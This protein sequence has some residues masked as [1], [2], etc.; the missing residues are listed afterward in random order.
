MKSPPLKYRLLVLCW[1]LAVVLY[2][3][4]GYTIY[5]A[6]NMTTLGGDG[7]KNYYTYLY[8]VCYSHGLWFGGMNYPFGEHCFY[9]DGQPL[10]SLPLSFIHQHIYRLTGVQALAIMHWSIGLSY[11]AGIYFLFRLLY[12]YGVRLLPAI[13]FSTLIMLLSPQVLKC[14]AHFALSNGAY[15]PGLFY[16]TAAFERTERKK[17]LRYLWLLGLMMCL[18]HLYFAALL[19]MWLFLYGLACLLLRKQTLKQKV[20]HLLW[21]G[22]A[23]V[24]A[25]LPVQLLLRL[26]DPV[27]DRPTIPFMGDDMFTTLPDIVT[28]EQSPIWQG[29]RDAGLIAKAAPLSEGTAYPGIAV[30]L[31]LSLAAICFI[32]LRIRRQQQSI[33][34]F[35]IAP[36]WIV[37]GIG[38][39]AIGNGLIVRLHHNWLLE[40]V[41]LLRQFRSFGRFSWGFYYI[42]CIVAVVWLNTYFI[43]KYWATRKALVLSVLIPVLGIW[44]IDA[45]GYILFTKRT[46]RDNNAKGNFFRGQDTW[47]NFLRSKG[48]AVNDFQCIYTL[49]YIHVGSEKIKAEEWVGGWVLSL[50]AIAAQET[51]LPLMDVKMART[52]W[53]QTF[54]QMKTSGGPFAGKPVLRRLPNDKLILLLHFEEIALTPDEQFLLSQS[55]LLGHFVQCNVYAVKPSAILKAQQVLTDSVQRIAQQLKGSDTCIGSTDPWFVDGF[56]DRIAPLHFQRKG[57]WLERRDSNRLRDYPLTW[58]HADSM[59]YEFSAWVH[60]SRNTPSCP[61]F[62]IDCIDTGRHVLQNYV[63]L[64]RSATDNHNLWLRATRYFYVPAAT[65]HIRIDFLS[66]NDLRERSVVDEMQLRPAAATIISRRENNTILVNNHLFRSR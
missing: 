43:E 34:A 63:A 60:I 54:E 30:L 27:T 19:V 8:Q 35:P 11:V 48:Y 36:L 62:S 20:V 42:V 29:I 9:T 26:T 18:H 58:P 64:G 65:R 49:P 47:T 55:T 21:F 13:A 56:E 24:G 51:A 25:I 2:V 38:F 45:N 46:F 15:V 12:A 10:L 4:S 23:I 17:Y 52:S 16:F 53:W 28:S 40:H 1:A 37:V 59:L 31:L 3:F 7:I 32:V 50:A 61:S 39:L 33:A 66:E 57:A 22:T 41:S 44:T 6:D 14:P 5:G